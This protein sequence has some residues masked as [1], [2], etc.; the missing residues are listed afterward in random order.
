MNALRKILLIEDEPAVSK[1]VAWCLE[2]WPGT[3]IDCVS[4]GTEAVAK[5]GATQYGLAIIDGRLPGA[6]SLQLVELAVERNIPVLLT[7][8]HPDLA[9]KLDE[10]GFPYLSKPF[11]L[12]SL[13]LKSQAIIAESKDNIRRVRASLETL[14]CQGDAL[15]DALNQSKLLIEDA[16]QIM[17]DA[18]K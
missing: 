12:D 10:A 3:Q 11:A 13:L 6:S 7:T 18:Q 14:K 5:I 8:G 1:V 17:Q 15:K 16:A 9:N 2:D 4:D